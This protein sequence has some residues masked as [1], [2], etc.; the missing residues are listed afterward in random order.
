MKSV[1]GMKPTFIVFTFGVVVLI[2]EPVF[3]EFLK[4]FVNDQLL[5]SFYHLLHVKMKKC[6]NNP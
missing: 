4:L 6:C 5:N 2:S 3:C 1:I